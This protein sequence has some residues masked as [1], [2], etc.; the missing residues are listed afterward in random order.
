MSAL[1]QHIG[2]TVFGIWT[3]DFIGTLALSSAPDQSRRE[4]DAEDEDD[5][6]ERGGGGCEDQ[7]QVEGFGAVEEGGVALLSGCLAAVG[8][9]SVAQRSAGVVGNVSAVD[10][11]IAGTRVRSV[12]RQFV[13]QRFA[14]ATSAA[15]CSACC[16]CLRPLTL[17][18]RM[19]SGIC[20][21][22]RD[23]CVSAHMPAAVGM[24]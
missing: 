8:G 10:L 18:H 13:Q 7:G 12:L 22:E 9:D 23:G 19:C 15:R 1:E 16:S 21:M 6:E 24:R 14:S 4:E 11:K 20:C 3:C 17:P 5:G 2:P